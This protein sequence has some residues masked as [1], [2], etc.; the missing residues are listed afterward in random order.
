MCCATES[1]SH[2]LKTYLNEEVIAVNQDVLG[3]RGSL[4]DIDKWSVHLADGGA[5]VVLLNRGAVQL[6][7]SFNLSD[8]GLSG[9]FI[10]RDLWLHEDIGSTSSTWTSEAVP[11]TAAAVL[12]LRRQKSSS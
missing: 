4:F 3:E 12:R 8:I 6:D 1:E 9:N 10:V 2:S 11:G 5:C 7:L